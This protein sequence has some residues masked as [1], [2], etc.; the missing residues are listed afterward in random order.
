MSTTWSRT[1]DGLAPTQRDTFERLAARRDDRPK[2]DPSVAASL[3]DDLS[4]RLAPVSSRLAEQ[5]FLNKYR[6]DRVLGCEVRP[7]D[8][9]EWTAPKARGT[10][11]HKAIELSVMRRD[12]P[13]PID[14]VD[15]AIGALIS[16]QR[17]LGDW[18]AVQEESIIARVRADASANLVA[19]LET[20]PPIDKAWW[21]VLEGTMTAEF[22]HVRLSGRPDLTIGRAEA[23]SAGKVIIDFKTG[24]VHDAHVADLRFYALID[25]L[26]IGTPPRML[27]TSYLDSGRLWTEDVTEDLLIAAADRVVDAAGRIATL[28]A[29]E[30]DPVKRPSVGCRWCPILDECEEGTAFLRSARDEGVLDDI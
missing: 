18:L 17:S 21:P 27:A 26:R 15:D 9:F 19:F 30:R 20:W 7:E 22:G 25:T 3:R 24:R 28:E 10:V 2:F 5:L 23:M 29:G 12:K 11:S 6:L 13:T 4:S 8:E 14:L 16:E 1:T